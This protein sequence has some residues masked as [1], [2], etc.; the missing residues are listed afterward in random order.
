MLGRT[1]RLSE[2]DCNIFVQPPPILQSWLLFDEQHYKVSD[3][4]LLIDHHTVAWPVHG[5]PQRHQAVT[6]PR[7][8]NLRVQA[9]AALPPSWEDDEHANV[10][11]VNNRSK[12][13][14][15]SCGNRGGKIK[16]HINESL[17]WQCGQFSVKWESVAHKRSYAYTEKITLNKN[18]HYLN[19]LM[20]C[21]HPIIQLFIRY[22]WSALCPR[23]SFPTAQ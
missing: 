23:T 20:F 12:R 9:F 8:S 22:V 19:S 1:R 4:I 17:I 16:C 21:H 13:N 2:L 7:R 14:T 15:P 10:V 6:H 18:S 11:P 3:P 5:C